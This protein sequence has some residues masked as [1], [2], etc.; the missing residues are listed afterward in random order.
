LHSHIKTAVWPKG[1]AG[2]IARQ[3][4]KVSICKAFGDLN[5]FLPGFFVIIA[6]V[7]VAATAG[8]VERLLDPCDW[9]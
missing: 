5:T 7:F 9:L 1:D 4:G 8:G 2:G 6:G 3:L